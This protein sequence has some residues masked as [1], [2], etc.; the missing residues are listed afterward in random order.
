MLSSEIR[1]DFTPAGQL[2]GLPIVTKSATT[3][4]HTVTSVTPSTCQDGADKTVEAD[5]IDVDFRHQFEFK[6]GGKVVEMHSTLIIWS[7]AAEGKIVRLQ[8]RPMGEISD[9]GLIT[10]SIVAARSG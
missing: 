4:S 9:N 2:L 3:L 10:V 1:I 5:K 6:L 8:D 7:S